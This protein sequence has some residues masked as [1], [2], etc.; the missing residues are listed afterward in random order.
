VAV[1]AE[2]LF[3]TSVLLPGLVDF[4]ETSRAPMRLMA[5]AVEPR[6]AK[7]HTAWHCCLE[8]FA[9]ATRLPEEFRLSAGEAVNLLEEDVLSH[10]RVHQLPDKRRMEFLRALA[11][12]G[13]VGG[14]I[15]DAHLAEIARAAG[16]HIVATENR[17]HFGHLVRHGIQVLTSAELVEKLGI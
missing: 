15:Y 14:R 11:S 16:A 13:L 2:V 6:A 9:V 12:E 1:V 7:P 17:R 10:F 8:F 5:A 3:D 4:G